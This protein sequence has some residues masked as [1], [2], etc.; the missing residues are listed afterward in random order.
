VTDHVLLARQS[1]AE[2]R[3]VR[4]AIELGDQP[5]QGGSVTAWR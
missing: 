3:V 2:L 1:Q 4:T 5:R